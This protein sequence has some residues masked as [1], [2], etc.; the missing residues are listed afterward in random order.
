GRGLARETPA[1]RAGVVQAAD[2]LAEDA[3][4]GLE[5]IAGIGRVA[6]TTS[7]RSART[8]R[9]AAPGTAAAPAATAARAAATAR[10]AAAAG[11]PCLVE[12]KQ[13]R[14]GIGRRPGDAEQRQHAAPVHGPFGRLD[15]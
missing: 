8:S 10:A 5:N 14:R 13:C 6:P 2:T 4:D 15:G 11:G 3:A 7:A 9:A 1:A 12:R